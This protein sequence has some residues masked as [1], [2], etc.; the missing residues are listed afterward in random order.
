MREKTTRD[1]ATR[2]AQEF[3]GLDPEGVQRLCL[4]F[5][6][7]LFGCAI[8]GEEVL[9]LKGKRKL[10]VYRRDAPR[11]ANARVSGQKKKL[12]AKRKARHEAK[13]NKQV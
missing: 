10:K 6:R 2:V 9:L 13:S 3:P 5:A 4:I 7:Q 1:Y 12:I 8:R 11:R